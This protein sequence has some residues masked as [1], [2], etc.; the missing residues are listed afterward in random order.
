MTATTTES[1]GTRPSPEANYRVLQR[2]ILPAENQRDTVALYVDGGA[3]TALLDRWVGL[4][5]ALAP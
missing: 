3:A 1:V 2:I 5:Q 4:T